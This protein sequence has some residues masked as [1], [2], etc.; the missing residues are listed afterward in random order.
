MSDLKTPKKIVE[1][2]RRRGVKYVRTLYVDLDSVIRGRVSP[3]DVFEEDVEH[4][5]TLAEVMQ[6]AF[7]LTD[8]LVPTSIYDPVGEVRLIPDINTIGIA[9][10]AP[11]HAMV[12]GEQYK[13]DGTPFEVDPRPKL[14]SI[15]NKVKYQIFV[16]YEPE[17]YLFKRIDGKLETFD[18][19]LCFA[20]TGMNAFSEFLSKLQE[21][22]RT[23]NIEIAHYYP[24]YGPGQHEISL[25]PYDPVKASDA[26]IMTREAVRGIA[27]NMG[28]IA[29]FMPKPS[30]TLPGSGLH[31]HVSLWRDDTNIFYSDTDKYH[32][33]DEA[34]WFI[35]GILKHIDALL[36]FTAPT[37]NSY[38]RLLPRRWASA[39][40]CWGPE[41]REAAIR[42]PLPP[43][44]RKSEAIHLEIKF[45]DNTIQPY[46]A[47]G[48]II[49]AGIKGIE[50]KIEPT[51]PCLVDP[52]MLSDEEREKR[53]WYRYPE[54]LLDALRA[55][56][57]DTF[58]KEVWGDIL[59]EEYIKLKVHQWYS[60]HNHVSDWEREKLL[61]VF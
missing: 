41:N 29:S 7:T 11:G 3:I 49:A 60:Y 34:Y 40:A 20:T 14:R 32:L 44:G 24:E 51:E 36:A 25:K 48:S 23:M 43:K 33:S 30:E 12:I 26:L 54:N 59:I 18:R 6:S 27:Q 52:A 39:Y 45:A 46:L 9:T 56:Q 53:G 10:W 28:L 42:I 35:G 13:A 57:R 17:F 38:K 2:L 22:L 31:I 1:E 4:G 58:F 15:L 50:Q 61:E 19:H 47:I 55:L 37:V 5:L 21:A 8:V 16:G